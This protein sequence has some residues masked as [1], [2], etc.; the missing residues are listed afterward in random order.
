MAAGIGCIIAGGLVSAIAA[1]VA[2][3]ENSSWAVAYL[4]LVG[5]VAQMV[6]GLGQARL[7]PVPRAFLAAEFVM[8]NGGNAAVMAGQ[9]L[10]QELILDA[11]GAILA[12]ALVLLIFG[13]RSAAPTAKLDRWGLLVYRAVM[14]VVLVSIPVGLVIGHFKAS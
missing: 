13:V 6:I 10:G 14:V 2:P 5:G 9:L 3:S 7:A 4:V 11:G 12:I 8:W 1:S